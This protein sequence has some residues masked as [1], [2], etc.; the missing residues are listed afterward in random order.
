MFK[1][2][3]PTTNTN[4]CS[5]PSPPS[6]GQ[7]LE[8][9]RK[10]HWDDP[11]FEFYIQKKK[12]NNTKDTKDTTTIKSNESQKNASE[13]QQQEK[14]NLSKEEIEEFARTILQLKEAKEYLNEK[15][16]ELKD[17]TSQLN[18]SA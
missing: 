15:L 17:L 5:F 8:D 13:E 11:L 12:E 3:I 14:N 16:N 1:K 2:K 9:L 4:L 6:D 7:M 18:K 10:A